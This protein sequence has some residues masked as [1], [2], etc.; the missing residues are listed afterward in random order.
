MVHK[1]KQYFLLIVFVAAFVGVA[2]FS[3]MGG[4]DLYGEEKILKQSVVRSPEDSYFKD[5]KFFN[6]VRGEPT[7]NM[8]SQ[9]LVV[10]EDF[11]NVNATFVDGFYYSK[12]SQEP[13]KFQAK[14]AKARPNQDQL[15]LEDDVVVLEQGHEFRSQKL[16]ILESGNRITGNENVQTISKIKTAGSLESDTSTLI[17]HSHAF[18][19]NAVLNHALYRGKVEGEMKRLKAYEEGLSFNTAEL[20]LDGLKGL[21]TLKGQVHIIKGKFEAWANSGEIFLENY[22]KKLKYYA[23]S[24]DVRLR[25]EFKGKEKPFERKAFAEK[26]EGWMNERKV[27]L[28]GFPKVIQE[29]DIIKGNRI[30]LRENSESV[31]IDDA[32]SSL[33]LK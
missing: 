23:L 1:I 11:T 2:L 3:F 29:K 33:I 18:D 14:K 10:S 21:I 16:K 22:N 27:I 32:N 8:H 12:R 31:E 24:D 28:T 17:I 19:Y 25:E 15:E 4:F 6:R 13:I 5:V 9:E 20:E 30:T 7:V 26:L